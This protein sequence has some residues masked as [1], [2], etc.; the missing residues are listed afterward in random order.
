MPLDISLS[1]QVMLYGLT[2]VFSAL[3]IL[4]GTVKIIALIFPF[5]EEKS[6]DDEIENG[7]SE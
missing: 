3:A 1:L 6:D 4:Y 7:E 2:G 5:K